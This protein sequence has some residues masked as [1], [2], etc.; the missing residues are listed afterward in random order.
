MQYNRGRNYMTQL[1]KQN[2]AAETA[3][4]GQ[5]VVVLEPK[6]RKF[7]ALNATSA[8]LWKK[9][10]QPASV[11]QL[12]NHIVDSYQNVTKSDALRDAQG[13]IDEMAALGIVLP[14]EH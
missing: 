13:I 10:Q 11:E 4:L 2:P 6:E 14:V 9:L 12:A 8:L 5:G 3:P 7:C 1:Y